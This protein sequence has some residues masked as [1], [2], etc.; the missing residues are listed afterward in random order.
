LKLPSTLPAAILMLKALS[1][2]DP[3]ATRKLWAADSFQ[4]L[5]ALVAQDGGQGEPGS[6]AAM[7]EEFDKNVAD[8]AQRLNISR[9]EDRLRVLQGWF[10]ETLPAAGIERIAFLRLDGD[11][12]TSTRDVLQALGDR[13]V[14]GKGRHEGR[15]AHL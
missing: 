6:Y 2:F 14:P 8:A 12:Y 9:V 10:N 5:P 11:L 1:D 4:G 15:A 3:G 7:R 13:V